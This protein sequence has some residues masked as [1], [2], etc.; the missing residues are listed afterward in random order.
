[1]TNEKLQSQTISF[2]R[3]PLIVGVVLIHSHF[4]EVVINGV[5][6]MKSDNFPVYTTISYLFSSILS[7]IAVPL[8]FFISGFLFFYKTTSFT[9][10]VYLQKLKKRVQTI[11]VPYIFWNL[12]V[13]AFFLLSQSFL[14]GLMSG[15]NKMIS[16]YSVSDCFWAFWNTNMITPP[17]GTDLA[18]YPICYQFWFIRDLM[19]MMLFSPLVYF[20]LIKLRQYAILC[21]GIIWFFDCWFNVVGF[22]ITAFFFFSAGAYFSVCQKNF[23]EIM[24]PLFPVIIM[25]YGLIAIAELYFMDRIWCDYLHNTGILI[26]MVA[27][28]TLT[29]HFIEKGKWQINSFLPN[30]S[31]FIYAYHAMPLALVSKVLFKLLKPHS[32]EMVLALYILCP[33]I[34]ILTGLLIYRLLKK[35]LP[36]IATLITG[37]R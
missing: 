21:L 22:S 5:D 37:G 32:D 6:F 2:L 4:N 19:V 28:I 13:I 9:G 34:I 31:F 30:S 11:L 23:V 33:T 25:L 7:A 36:R 26:G 18:A 17:T 35:C 12:L 15:K 3:F 14:P 24:K 20:L 8:F 29:V 27:A 16:D 10:Q 1:M